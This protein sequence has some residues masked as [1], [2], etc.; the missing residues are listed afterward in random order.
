MIDLARVREYPDTV[1]RLILK[2]DPAFPVDRFIELERQQSSLKREIEHLRSE[3]NRLAKGAQQG[4]TPE[5]RQESQRIG[6]ELKEKERGRYR[7][8]FWMGFLH[9]ICSSIKPSLRSSLQ[10]MVGAGRFELPTSC[11]PSK[12]ASRATLRP[13]P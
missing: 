6:S 13:E 10:K 9:K 1:K 12:R 4:I 2:K 7:R 5:I 3:K 8:G 11:T